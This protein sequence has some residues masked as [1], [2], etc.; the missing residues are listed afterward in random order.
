MHKLKEKYKEM[1]MEHEERIKKNP[2][3][4]IS[5]TD[6]QVIEMLSGTLK[7]LC[8][9]EMYE[10]YGEGDSHYGDMPYDSENSYRRGRMNAKRD[11]MGRYSRD[12][13]Y[14]EDGYSERGTYHGNG[15]YSYGSSKEEMLSKIDE[16]K[17]EI[18]KM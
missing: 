15:S 5:G 16:M 17:R 12:G 6:M 7:N 8:K 18:E 13:G 1:L 14:S 3:M 10:Q 9:I 11:S 2:S 4:R